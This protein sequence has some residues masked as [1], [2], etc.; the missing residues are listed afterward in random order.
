MSDRIL[1][2]RTAKLRELGVQLSIVDHYLLIAERVAPL[3][4]KLLISQSL[5]DSRHL[6]S[7]S[8]QKSSSQALIDLSFTTERRIRTPA[9]L[10]STGNQ[11]IA[12]Q[13]ID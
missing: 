1:V 4:C 11:P 8:K 9:T 5:T 6:S 7:T 3:N 10:T 2:K 13:S 12:P